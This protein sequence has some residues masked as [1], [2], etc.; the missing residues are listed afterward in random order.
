MFFLLNP[1][2]DTTYVL[3]ILHLDT[4]A[5]KQLLVYG[6]H[7]RTLLTENR[8]KPKTKRRKEKYYKDLSWQALNTFLH[9]YFA[10]ASL[11]EKAIQRFKLM[12][13]ELLVSGREQEKVECTG[14][15]FC[16]PY[17][18]HTDCHLLHISE[19]S[20]ANP[21]STSSS[22]S[23]AL[24]TIDFCRGTGVVKFKWVSGEWRK[25]LRRHSF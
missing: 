7:S 14:T 19:L 10:I 1:A 18:T 11:P 25:T 8:T 23:F 2:Q 12:Q 16:S 21:M 13:C 3:K 5:V 24:R 6:A 22:E 15:S 17:K 20:A 4:I 9:C